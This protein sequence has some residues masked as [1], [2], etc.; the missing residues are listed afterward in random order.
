[1]EIEVFIFYYK[2]IQIV[3]YGFKNSTDI[4]Q[5]AREY[6]NNENLSLEEYLPEIRTSLN[7]LQKKQRTPEKNK[8]YHFKS[9]KANILP[10]T[11]VAFNK[12]GTR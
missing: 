9:L 2:M 7:K 1:M 11:N 5:L 10:I 3:I 8:F 12:E 6:C 4:E